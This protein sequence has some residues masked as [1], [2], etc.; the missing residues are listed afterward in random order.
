[1]LNREEKRWLLGAVILALL[2]LNT[3]Y[4]AGLWQS[5]EVQPFTGVLFG[6]EDTY[7][8][9]TKMRAGSDNG[10]LFTNQ[11]AVE[12]HA[13]LP[14]YLFYTGMG[15]LLGI[16]N[17]SDTGTFVLVFHGLRI[18][19]SVYLM[20]MMYQLAARM[21]EPVVWRRTAWLFALFGGGLGWLLLLLTGDPLV[22]GVPLDFYLNEAVVYLPL[23]HLPHA[24]LALAFLIHGVLSLDRAM[25]T[26][27]F[28][29]A[30]F[31]SLWWGLMTLLIPFYLAVAAG[32]V[33]GWLFTKLLLDREISWRL[34]ICGLLAGALGSFYA[35][36]VLFLTSGDAVYEAWQAQNTL[37]SGR[38][39][40]LVAA[41]GV[42]M[43]VA[44]Y[45][46]VSVVRQRHPNQ[47]LLVGW[48]LAPW[49]L[50]W[51][52][53]PYQLRFIAGLP[54]IIGMLIPI[55]VQSLADRISSVGARFLYLSISGVMFPTLLFLMLGSTAL[56]LARSSPAFLPA[57]ESKAAS[58][59]GNYL[60][61]PVTVVLSGEETGVR[62]PAYS[63][64][65]V[66]VGHGFETPRYAEK[67][68]EVSRFFTAVMTD[69][70]RMELLAD[71][72]VTHV[73]Y[74]QFER[75]MEC[76]SPCP[77]GTS[78]EAQTL[79]LEPVFSEGQVIIYRVVDE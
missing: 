28:E 27:R 32:I 59:V 69:E 22:L 13:H 42:Q 79:P 54:V 38:P 40:A 1:M 44:C 6:I 57:D 21:W 23:L 36:L 64:V 75:S 24:T 8:Y 51:L 46:A 74:G 52:P 34:I 10:I 49:L 66:V 48:L 39:L 76:P 58:F 61:D 5:T 60:H 2:V 72:E 53:L 56:V 14:V 3:P 70:Q 26:V 78:F 47:T 18:V 65:R 37:P 4:I 63:A 77:A 29:P 15:W 20:V 16:L 12:P 55:G 62:L 73:Y 25:E 19:A 33:G 9:L 68:S 41:F 31:A 45:G 50:I 67:V 43:C 17:M 7:S 35:V 11:Y 30:L 71:Y